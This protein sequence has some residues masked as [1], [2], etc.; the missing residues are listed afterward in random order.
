VSRSSTNNFAAK[1][2]GAA[3]ALIMM[4]APMAHA[5]GKDLHQ[6]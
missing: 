6:H 5:D 1:A 4:G 2:A 3:A